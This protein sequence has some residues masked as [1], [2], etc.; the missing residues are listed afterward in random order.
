MAH[1]KEY[2]ILSKLNHSNIVK[3]VGFFENEFKGEIH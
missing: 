3:S 1:K 2:E